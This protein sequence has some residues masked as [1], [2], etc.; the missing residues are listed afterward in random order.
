MA[1]PYNNRKFLLEGTR[2]RDINETEEFSVNATDKVVFVTG[3]GGYSINST[4][5]IVFDTSLAGVSA[6]VLNANGFSGGIV[7]N[8]LLGGIDANSTGK[9]SFD[10]TANVEV[11][12]GTGITFTGDMGFYGGAAVSKPTITGDMTT[13]IAHSAAVSGILQSII[14]AL[15]TLGLATDGTT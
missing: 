11:I 15:E 14:S 3:T 6:I 2:N 12:G 4:G 1:S 10:T 5:Q 7:L 13:A 9:I 8:T